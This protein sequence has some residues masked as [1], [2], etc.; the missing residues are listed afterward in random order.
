M[1]LA[2]FGLSILDWT[3]PTCFCFCSRN[4]FSKTKFNKIGCCVCGFVSGC[5][6]GWVFW[7]DGGQLNRW[8]R[9]LIVFVAFQ[10]EGKWQRFDVTF[11]VHKSKLPF[12][13]LH[14][15]SESYE[16]KLLLS[17]STS[18]HSYFEVHVLHSY[19]IAKDTI[20]HELLLFLLD[21]S[22]RRKPGTTRCCAIFSRAVMMASMRRFG[23]K[24]RKMIPCAQPK[25]TVWNSSNP[26]RLMLWQVRH[27][28]EGLVVCFCVHVVAVEISTP[29]TC[30]ARV[31]GF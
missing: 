22:A 18:H 8:M 31:G 14:E 16:Y 27:K 7:D 12:K 3:G 24:Y 30:A 29:I 26:T 13:S 15:L 1:L 4:W 2:F 6:A 5:D 19:K 28:K 25:P 10:K 11:S 17:E 21:L 20:E 23:K 9:A